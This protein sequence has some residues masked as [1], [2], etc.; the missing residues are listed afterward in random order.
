[1]SGASGAGVFISE[2]Q[3]LTGSELTLEFMLNGLRLTEGVPLQL[4]RERTGL[5]VD[6]LEKPLFAAR[7]KGLMT[8]DKSQLCATPRGRRFLND[9][10]LLFAS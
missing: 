8:N 5:S 7:E 9:L 3:D 2:E 10:L 4:F 1:M 6:V